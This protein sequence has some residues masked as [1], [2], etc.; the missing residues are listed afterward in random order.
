ML[1]VVLLSTKDKKGW[2]EILSRFN[3]KDPHYLPGYLEI[4]EKES[5]TEPFMHFG[6]LGMLFVYGDSSNFIIY[7]FLKRS[8]S[9]LPFSDTSVDGLYDIVSPYG[10][11]GPLAQVED[12]SVSEELWRGFF[13][14]FDDFCKENN[15]VSEFCRLH[16]LFENHEPVGNFSKGVTR[17]LGQIV[18]IDLSRSEEEMLAAMHNHRRRHIRRALENPDLGFCLEKKEE[19]CRH[20]FG[21]YTET[22]HRN[23]ASRKY[24]FSQGFFDTAFRSLGEHVM[25]AYIHYKGDIISSVLLLSYGDIMCNWLAASKTEYHRFHPNDLLYY[26]SFLQSKKEGF[27]YYILGGGLSSSEDS[28]FAYKAHFSNSFKDFYVYKRIHLEKEYKELV[29]LKRK[30]S[31]EISD[32]FFPQYRTA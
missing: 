30:Y 4:Y 6:G 1:Q 27:R 15:I 5:N 9:Y 13:D 32:D 20:F 8:L 28:L 21:L 14:T 22:M 26:H 10:Y 17:Q 11:G 29:E 24:F 23:S 3:R 31:M 19:N 12:E 18:Y 2:L 25:C 16:P 7:P